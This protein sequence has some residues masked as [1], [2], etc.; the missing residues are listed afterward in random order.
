MPQERVQKVLA[1]VGIAS[2]RKAEELIQEGA[3]T[4]NGKIAKLGD[5]AE[6]GKDAI[7]VNGKLLQRAE[8]PVYFAFYKPKGVISMLTDPENRPTLA[9]YLGKVRSRV[10]PI[11]RLDFNSEGLILLTNDGDYAEKIQRHG[12]IL[13]VFH[14]KVRGHMTEEMVKRL[15]RGAKIG[16]RMVRPQIVR[17]SDEYASKTQVE[18]IFKGNASVDLKAY[19][20]MKGFL[21]ERITRAA[22]GH[23]TLR[24]LVPGQYK[25]LR[26]TQ[27]EALLNQP[28]LATR[29]L[30]VEVQARKPVAIRNI[31]KKKVAG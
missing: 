16:P 29:R 6:L 25:Q 2:R 8:T 1:K 11:G 26:Q 19:F 22:I 30:E 10:F 28:E 21:V 3:V 15:Q 9:D 7:K 5:K 13:K 18:I 31:H 17:V 23:I 4:I 27:A 20:E 24:G 14:V 12:E